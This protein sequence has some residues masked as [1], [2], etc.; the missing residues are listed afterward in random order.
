MAVQKSMI[1]LQVNEKPVDAYLAAPEGG[2]PG[3][4]V[5]HAWWGLNPFFKAG[6]RGDWLCRALLFWPPI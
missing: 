4:L 6:M 5:L 2:G 1:Q 3:I